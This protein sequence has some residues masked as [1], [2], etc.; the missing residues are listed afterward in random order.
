MNTIF[1]TY[2]FIFGLIFWSFGSVLIFRWRSWKKWII[3]GRSECPSCQHTLTI[4]DLIPFFS[5]VF[6]RWKCRH[7]RSKIWPIYPLLELSMWVLFLLTWIFLVDPNLIFSFNLIE[8][9][10]LV[11]FLFVSFV[12]VIFTFYDI[13]YLEIPDEILIPS[14]FIIFFL[15][16]IS[17]LIKDFNIFNYFSVFSSNIL[18]IPIINWVIWALLIFSFFLL[19]IL[20]SK[21]AWMWWWDLRIAVFM[22]LIWWTKIALLWLLI[23]YFLG[24]IFGIIILIKT[25]NKENKIPFWPYLWAW[26]FISLMFHSQIVNWYFSIL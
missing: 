17:S 4:L 2:L 3:W 7:C 10:K 18:N 1:Y 20:V 11:L 25:R 5:Y 19:Q 15:L 8:I 16:I 21:W 22:W 24:S 23:A 14:I 9:M 6:L 13:L 26:I 12:I